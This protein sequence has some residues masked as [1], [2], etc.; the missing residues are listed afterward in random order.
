VPEVVVQIDL[1]DREYNDVLAAA[2]YAEFADRLRAYGCRR[3]E[4]SESRQ[5]IVIDR[6]NPDADIL[7]ISE[8]PGDNED[9]TGQAFVGRAGELLD[10]MLA[11]IDLDSNR[12]VLIANIVKCK[13]AQDR[14]PMAGE[15]EACL[16]YL[17]KQIALVEPRFV[18]LLGAV[19]LKWIDGTRREFTM[20]EEAG[21]FFELQRYPGIRFMVLY[22]PAF[23]LRDPRKKRVTWEHLKQLRRAL[24]ESAVERSPT[25]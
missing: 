7:F 25:S 17:E 15:A 4:L 1:F 2:H 24:D 16:P 10:R 3:C 8:R 22:H 21:R 19:A 18:V 14:P 12:D 11:A 13:P 6:G 23:L 20:E 5:H 9:Q